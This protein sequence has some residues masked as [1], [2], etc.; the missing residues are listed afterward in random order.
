MRMNRTHQPP[1]EV[2][3]KI[4]DVFRDYGYEGATLSRI[5]RATGLGRSSLYHYFP[6]GKAAMMS[7][8]LDAVEQL[9][10]EHIVGALEQ[11]GSPRVKI[12]AMISQLD[13]YYEGGNAACL[14]GV[15]ALSG[16]R[17]G[18]KNRLAEMFGKWID[19]LAEVARE[20]GLQPDLARRRA[21][22]VVVRIQGGLVLSAGLGRADPF[23]R[24][25]EEIPRLLI[26]A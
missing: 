1:E 17:A 24:A 16:S 12:A 19:A 26:R 9:L 20:A 23:R 21:E 2:V 6:R 4:R 18:H 3:A 13:F 10:D 5:A 15:L 7:S 11:P 14:L 25:L 22:E 8:A